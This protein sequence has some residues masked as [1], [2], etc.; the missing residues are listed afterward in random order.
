MMLIK[1]VNVFQIHVKSYH[2]KLRLLFD[3]HHFRENSIEFETVFNC[4]Q[5]SL[6]LKNLSIFVDLISLIFVNSRQLHF[7]GKVRF[8][9]TCPSGNH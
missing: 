4:L 3:S 2:N 7:F 6:E 9:H 8:L 5:V 1:K